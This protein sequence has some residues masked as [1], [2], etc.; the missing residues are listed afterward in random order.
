MVRPQIG[1]TVI[2][3]ILVTFSNAQAGDGDLVFVDVY[4][5]YVWN[6]NQDLAL[7]YPSS[8][9]NSPSITSASRACWLITA[10]GRSSEPGTIRNR[11]GPHRDKTSDRPS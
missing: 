4:G 7:E 8:V 1:F 11:P 6:Q 2:F 5:G 10:V 9:G 3:A